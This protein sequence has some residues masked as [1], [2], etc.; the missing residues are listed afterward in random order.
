MNKR[1]LL[2]ADEIE[3]GLKDLPA[4]SAVDG[5]LHREFVFTD[6]VEAFGFMARAA[7]IAEKKDHH[8]NW[9]NVYNRVIVDLYTHDSGGITGWDLDL[10]G[11]FEK[12]SG[13]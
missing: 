2:T 12:I 4:W 7:I 5:K 11:S 10:A 8:P 3:T 6:F 13:L 9:S 1:I